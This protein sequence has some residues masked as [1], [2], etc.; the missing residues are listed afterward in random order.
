[1]TVPRTVVTGVI[2]DDIHEF[3]SRM[4]ARA[5]EEAGYRV[6]IL[7]VMVPQ[8]RFVSAAVEHGA[9]A[10][11]INS[12]SGHALLHCRGLRE[13]CASAG[14]AKVLLYVGG[15]IQPPAEPWEKACGAFVELG[16]D[17]AYPPGTRAEQVIADLRADLMRVDKGGSPGS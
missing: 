9:C 7:G 12:V 17:R 6:I 10:I 14:L 15:H 2:G 3:G 5:L 8:E 13:L 11:L 4:M 1:M 16:F